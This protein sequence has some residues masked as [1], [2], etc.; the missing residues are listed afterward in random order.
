MW[1]SL[2]DDTLERS[3]TCPLPGTQQTYNSLWNNLLWDRSGNRIKRASTARHNTERLEEAE[4]QPCWGNNH[5]PATM[6]LSQE[7][8]Q[9]YGAFPRGVGDLSSTL[10]TPAL[11]F[12]VTEKRSQNTW[13]WKPMENMPRKTIEL[14]EKKN[15]LLKGPHIDL[16]NQKPAQKHQIEKYMAHW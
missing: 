10:G 8:S 9:R 14:Q 2:E 6:L 12:S 5:T 16:L 1:E 13:L 4:I 3:R 11:R 7:S 15:L